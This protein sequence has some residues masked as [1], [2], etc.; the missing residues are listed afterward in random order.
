[1]DENGIKVWEQFPHLVSL[2]AMHWVVLVEVLV[3]AVV[4]LVQMVLGWL[5]LL[6][7]DPG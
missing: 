3:G 6:G 1:M 4:P 7:G 2:P 5:D